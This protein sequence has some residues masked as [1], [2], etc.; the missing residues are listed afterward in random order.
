MRDTYLTVLQSCSIGGMIAF[1]VS[2]TGR[3]TASAV[4][5]KT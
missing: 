1:I 2:V 5:V 4:A 3:I